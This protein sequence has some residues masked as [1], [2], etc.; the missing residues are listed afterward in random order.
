ME[1]YESV[2]VMVEGARA[3]DADAVTGEWT[4]YYEMM[5]DAT[6]NDLMYSY[7]PT[8]GSYYDVTGIVNGRLD[9]YKLEPRIEEDITSLTG[10]DPELNVDFG[11]Y[12]NPFNDMINIKNSDR[13]SRVV[14]SNIAG[15]RVIDI[16]YPK[17][18]I[19]TAKLVSGVYIVSMYTENGIAK[20]VRIVKR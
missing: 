11:A 17:S 6:V 15:Q 2:L 12:P 18:E 9:D 8:D 14:I 20:S 3:S 7:E 13:L 19:R 16:E 4:I 1:M 5:D 10:V